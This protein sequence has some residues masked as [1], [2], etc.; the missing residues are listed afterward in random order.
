MNGR[1]VFAGVLAVA[2]VAGL[3]PLAAQAELVDFRG[4]IEGTI[5]HAMGSCYPALNATLQ[6]SGTASHMGR[7]DALC[8]HCLDPGTGAVSGGR[9]EIA[10]ASG[11]KLYANYTGQIVDPN[12]LRTVILLFGNWD[13]GTGRFA[14]ATGQFTATGVRTEGDIWHSQITVEATRQVTIVEDGQGKY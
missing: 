14:G 8:T 9:F 10:T 1:A 12:P 2:L 4:H 13:G 7:I 6:G 11:D 3:A 5:D